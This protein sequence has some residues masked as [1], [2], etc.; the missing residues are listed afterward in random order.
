MISLTENIKK[1]EF[2]I[3]YYNDKCGKIK[4]ILISILPFEPNIYFFRNP[5]PFGGGLRDWDDNNLYEFD[6]IK[7]FN[8]F[9]IRMLKEYH[10]VLNTIQKDLQSIENDLLH[11]LEIYDNEVWDYEQMDEK[12]RDMFERDRYNILRPIEKMY[13]FKRLISQDEYSFEYL[14]NEI[15]RRQDKYFSDSKIDPKDL[16]EMTSIFYNNLKLD[17]S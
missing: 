16:I 4:L 1:L 3:K 6:E 14:E 2:V 11:I 5:G 9:I 10:K 12:S 17:I 7:G 13:E 15:K 8:L